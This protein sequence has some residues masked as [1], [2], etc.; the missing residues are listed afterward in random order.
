LPIQNQQQPA[1]R[2][3]VVVFLSLSHVRASSGENDADDRSHIPCN[4]SALIAPIA[5]SLQ[6]HPADAAKPLTALSGSRAVCSVADA[7]SLAEP[8]G[9]NKS[10]FGTFFR[11]S[12]QLGLN[13]TGALSADRLQ[14]GV[15]RLYFAR[16]GPRPIIHIPNPAALTN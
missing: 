2:Q 13:E 1:L 5:Q 7:C 4:H 6:L 12:I 14:S 9:N 10:D 16:S 15:R 11:D 8:H 3:N